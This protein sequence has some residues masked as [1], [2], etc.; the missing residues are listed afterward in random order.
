MQGEETYYS[1]T[2]E[3][4]TIYDTQVCDSGRACFKSEGHV[5][6][7]QKGKRINATQVILIAPI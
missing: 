7:T 3:G 1:Q 2:E 6:V 4:K 5:T